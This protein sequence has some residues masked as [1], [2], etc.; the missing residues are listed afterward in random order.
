MTGGGWTGLDGWPCDHPPGL[1]DALVALPNA[2]SL[3]ADELEAK[4]TLLTAVAEGGK[5]EEMPSAR[6]ATAA[7]SDKELV[8]LHYL[9]RKLT[10]HIETMHEPAISALHAEGGDHRQLVNAL[11]S[12]VECA[13]HAY[14]A[15]GAPERLSGRPPKVAAA[16]VT[17]IA[18]SI[19]KQITGRPATFTSDP[20]TS[21]VSGAWPDFLGKIFSAFMINASV[22]S[23]VK[24][25]KSEN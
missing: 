16:A 12:T 7:A 19:F 2:G 8:R 11:Q 13:R 6:P 5:D 25:R 10:D 18:A 4:A 3:G 14:G 1:I 23:Q 20:A 9:C 21:H 22:A 24:A 17:E 15:T